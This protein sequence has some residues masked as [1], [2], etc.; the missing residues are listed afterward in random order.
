MKKQAGAESFIVRSRLIASF[1]RRLRTSFGQMDGDRDGAGGGRGR[2]GGS[3]YGASLR[4]EKVRIMLVEIAGEGKE[5]RGGESD[6][7]V[8]A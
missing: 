5:G 8:K 6:R 7:G 1:L 4:L 3:R 2:A